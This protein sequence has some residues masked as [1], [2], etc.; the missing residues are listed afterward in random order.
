[1]RKISCTAPPQSSVLKRKLELKLEFRVNANAGLKEVS[2]FGRFC[3]FKEIDSALRAS[4]RTLSP[5]ETQ[6]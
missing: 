4:W 5:D 3:S 2:D 1:V 6:L